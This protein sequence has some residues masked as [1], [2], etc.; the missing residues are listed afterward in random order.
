MPV[1][2]S[3][4]DRLAFE[5]EADFSAHIEA[6]EPDWVKVLRRRRAPPAT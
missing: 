1:E 3:G 2:A 4:A 5:Y 6:F